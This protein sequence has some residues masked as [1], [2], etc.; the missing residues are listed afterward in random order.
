MDI[1]Y[2]KLCQRIYIFYMKPK[3]PIKYLF[4]EDMNKSIRIICIT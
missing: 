2:E 4:V 3:T 1:M